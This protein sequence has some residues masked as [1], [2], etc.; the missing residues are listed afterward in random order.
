[1]TRH[2]FWGLGQPFRA[3]ARVA[4]TSFFTACYEGMAESES[5]EASRCLWLPGHAD[6]Y[7]DLMGIGLDYLDHE[8]AE[9]L[10]WGSQVGTSVIVRPFFLK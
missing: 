5:F 3:R 10:S 7:V 8:L 2:H 4:S 9:D 6:Q 1:M